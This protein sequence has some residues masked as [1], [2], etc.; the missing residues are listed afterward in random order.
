M[1]VKWFATCLSIFDKVS[2]WS[3]STVIYANIQLCSWAVICLPN[4]LIHMCHMAT[5]N[6][7]CVHGKC[8]INIT[9]VQSYAGKYH[10]F[11]AICMNCMYMCCTHPQ[12]EQQHTWT[13][14][15]SSAFD[16]LLIYLC[17]LIQ[18]LTLTP[19]P[20]N[21][22]LV[23]MDGKPWTCEEALWSEETPQVLRSFCVL[24]GKLRCNFCWEIHGKTWYWLPCWILKIL[25]YE[26]LATRQDWHHVAVYHISSIRRHSYNFFFLFVWVRL[27][28]E[29]SVYFTPECAATI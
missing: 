17:S 26:S 19:P 5:C 28:F 24:Y 23:N 15:L 21:A 10:K 2:V 9:I 11:V 22:L 8:H 14:L 16:L 18:T 6:I 12:T 7:H 25:R 13:T 3:K 29:G 1:Y 27:L 20:N 4:S